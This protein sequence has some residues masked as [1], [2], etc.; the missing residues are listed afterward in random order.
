MTKPACTV[1]RKPISQTELQKRLLAE[2]HGA[3]SQ[4]SDHRLELRRVEAVG[5]ARVDH[6]RRRRPGHHGGA[7]HVAALV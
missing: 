7:A 3:L 6:H 5:E 1:I 4:R 2:A